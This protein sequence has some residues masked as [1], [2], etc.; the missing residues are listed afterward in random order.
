MSSAS[1]GS[2]SRELV[3]VV[4][5]PVP[6][7]ITALLKVDLEVAALDD[8]DVLDA[9]RTL[10]SLVGVSLQRDDVA[11]PV[12]AVGGDQRAWLRRR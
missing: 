6:P 12:A 10:E 11:P 3:G 4:H 7:V 1:I 8:D 9:G 2:G 5:E